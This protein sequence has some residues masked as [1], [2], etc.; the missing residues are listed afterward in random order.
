MIELSSTQPSPGYG[1]YLLPP[2]M[3][4]M[5]TSGLK[6]QNG[7]G[8]DLVINIKPASDVGTWV[9]AGESRVWLYT[10]AATVGIS[11]ES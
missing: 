6:A 3:R 7:P 9:G 4:V 8:A 10:I 1:V 11:P 5:Q 2:L